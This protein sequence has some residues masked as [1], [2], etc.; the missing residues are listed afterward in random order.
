LIDKQ[1]AFGGLYRQGQPF[2]SR[3]RMS[4]FTLR[5]SSFRSFRV[6]IRA[7][8]LVLAGSTIMAFIMTVETALVRDRKI[9]SRAK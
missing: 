3:I 5:V 7:I 4:V 6:R 8:M 2:L 9:G 1:I